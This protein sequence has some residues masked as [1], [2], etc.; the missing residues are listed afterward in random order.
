MKKHLEGISY[1]HIVSLR[2][3]PITSAKGTDDLSIGFDRDR[4]KRQRDLNKNK[5]RENTISELCLIMFS[6]L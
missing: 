2:Y 6:V 3:E 4:V 1:A 5:K